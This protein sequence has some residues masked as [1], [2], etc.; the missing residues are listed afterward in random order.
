M[1]INMNNNM[2]NNYINHSG[3]AVGADFEW[4][5]QG[6]KYGVVTRH[7]WH[8]CRTPYGNVEITEEDSFLM[9]V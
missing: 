3:G 4:G 9:S 1:L 6:A 5:R 7:Y 8:G 2:K